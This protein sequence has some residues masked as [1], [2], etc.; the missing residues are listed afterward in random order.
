MLVMF[1]ISLSVL[2]LYYSNP[3]W[4]RHD[5][6]AIQ[7]ILFESHMI[8]SRSL[9]QYD[10]GLRLR[11]VW[12]Q[13]IVT[14]CNSQL[15]PCCAETHWT[16][17]SRWDSNSMILAKYRWGNPDLS[18]SL[19]WADKIMSKFTGFRLYCTVIIC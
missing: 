3:I 14:H 12:C 7:Y 10:T 4:D 15:R 17:D 5:I 16:F 11:W 2:Y 1:G 18:Q 13:Q 6:L 19:S 9:I 8:V